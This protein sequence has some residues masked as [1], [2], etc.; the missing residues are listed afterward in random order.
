MP[1]LFNPLWINASLSF[2]LSVCSNVS[3]YLMT[4][5]DKKA[6]FNFDY[7]R[8]VNAFS[9][10]FSVAIVLPLIFNFLIVCMGMKLSVRN[11]GKL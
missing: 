9:L 2:C 1:D 5:Y 7:R 6:D 8:V 11:I 4:D 10:V 3:H